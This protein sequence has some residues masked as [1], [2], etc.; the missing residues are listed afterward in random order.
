MSRAFT[1]E[2]GAEPPFVAPRAPLP[3]EVPNYVTRRGLAALRE[4]RAALE[5]ARPKAEEADPDTASAV[6]AYQARL[7]ALEARI[8]S[9]VLVD[10]AALAHDEVRFSAEVTLQSADGR[11]RRYRI[12]GVDEADAESG[13]IAFLSPLARE[14]AGKRV[15][16]SIQVRSPHGEEELEIAKIDYAQES[17]AFA[18]S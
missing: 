5:A 1:K 7:G 14:L 4:E 2:D 6:A 12:V 10:P 3:A 17:V 16:D 9:A 13:H 18:T 15:G 11:E 8:A